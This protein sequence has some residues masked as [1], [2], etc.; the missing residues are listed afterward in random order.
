M[1]RFLTLRPVSYSESE[2][3]VCNGLLLGLTAIRS[4]IFW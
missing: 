1:T 2:K 4:A 3:N